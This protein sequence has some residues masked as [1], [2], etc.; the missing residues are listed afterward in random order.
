LRTF[1]SCVLPE[2]KQQHT[3]ENE[4][5]NLKERLGERQSETETE[6]AKGCERD[7]VCDFRAAVVCVRGKN[8]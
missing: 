4:R 7:K 5:A 6:E 1:L 2:D 8:V 3:R